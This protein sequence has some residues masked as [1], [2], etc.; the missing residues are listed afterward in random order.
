MISPDKSTY[1][2]PTLQTDRLVLRLLAN[3]DLDFIFH[4]FSDPDV[5][6]YLMDDPPVAN[7]L[8]AQA[9]IDFFLEPESK[10][11]V[12][13]VLVRKE[14]QRVIGTCGFHRWEKPYF[15]AEMG[16][17]LD[18]RY[19][20][21][22]YMT[23]ALRAII[24]HGFEHMGL[25]RIDAFVYVGNP[26]SARILEKFGFIQEG[27]LR[28]YFCLDGVFYDHFLFGLVKRDWIK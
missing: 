6:R 5:T 18:P 25:N 21:Q 13:W 27:L 28:D 14:D 3:K 12:R 1:M 15:R 8:E 19:W 9:I 10:N 17:D 24:K 7:M 22:G 23:E 16:Y 11:R 2:F 20:R 26:R 4:H